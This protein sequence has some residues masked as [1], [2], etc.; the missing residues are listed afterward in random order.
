MNLGADIA[1]VIITWLV[2]GGVTYGLMR[3]KLDSIGDRITKMEA[4]SERDV[5]LYVTR[6]EYESRHQDIREQLARIESKLDN[7]WGADNVS[8]RQ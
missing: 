7:I 6:T 4:R 5:S 8:K 3:G 2:T 1:V